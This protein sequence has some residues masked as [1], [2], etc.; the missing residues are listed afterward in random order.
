[1]H[2][3]TFRRA[4]RPTSARPPGRHPWAAGAL[5]VA[6]VVLLTWAGSSLVSA[7]PADSGAGRAQQAGQEERRGDTS[8][9]QERAERAARKATTLIEPPLAR[10]TGPLQAGGA[11]GDVTGDVTVQPPRDVAEPTRIAIPQL[12][13]DQDLTELAVIGRTLQVPDD[14]DD[15][16]WWGGGPVPGRQG[17]A[18]VVGHVDSP[19]GPAVFYQLSG[20]TPGTK[21]QISL[22]NGS[23][24]AFAVT[25]VEVFDKNSFPSSRVYQSRGRPGL[26]LV[27]CGGTFD[28]ET[29]QY[30]SN[31]VVSARLIDRIPADNP[32]ATGPDTGPNR[33]PSPG[34]SGRGPGGGSGRT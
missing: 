23:R 34:P 9:Q 25:D 33:S 17:S 13:I 31:V 19:T 26:F 18:V 30:S 6:S 32:S 22:E 8:A 24:A 29:K 14:Y 21:V 3:N 10:S 2:Q 4:G 15:I 12:G 16:G 27:T 20:I 1:M 11:T 7:S 28:T 5:L